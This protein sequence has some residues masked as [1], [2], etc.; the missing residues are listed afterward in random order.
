[1]PTD[2]YMDEYYDSIDRRRHERQEKLR[3]RL[4]DEFSVMSLE[5][6]VKFIL[7]RYIEDKVSKQG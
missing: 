3:Q 5:E 2:R 6:K 4:V 1:M 7:D